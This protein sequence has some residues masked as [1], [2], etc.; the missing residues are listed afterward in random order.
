MAVFILWV[1]MRAA[2]KVDAAVAPV[3]ADVAVLTNRVN[4]FEIRLTEAED[5]IDG[6]PSKADLEKVL[7]EARAA[8]SEGA[9]ANAGIRRIESFFLQRG[10]ERS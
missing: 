10:V 2:S 5:D 4:A 3:K 9:A 8:H 1:D 7:S 6:L